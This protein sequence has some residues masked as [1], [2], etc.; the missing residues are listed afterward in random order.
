MCVHSARQITFD[1]CH[2]V[3]CLHQTCCTFV[4]IHLPT[5]DSKLSALLC[6]DFSATLMHPDNLMYLEAFMSKIKNALC[7]NSYAAVEFMSRQKA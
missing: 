5:T 4:L 6:F 2:I 7:P 3:D 1:Q